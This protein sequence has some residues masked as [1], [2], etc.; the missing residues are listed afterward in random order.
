MNTKVPLEAPKELSYDLTLEFA[1]TSHVILDSV[2][3]NWLLETGTCVLAFYNLGSLP[4]HPK[5]TEPTRLRNLYQ[6]EEVPAFVYLPFFLFAGHLL[7][8]TLI[9]RYGLIR[10]HGLALRPLWIQKVSLLLNPH[11]L[12]LD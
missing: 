4:I 12:W 1:F 7:S 11:L 9:P 8:A 6:L 3:T 10:L 5:A 2:S